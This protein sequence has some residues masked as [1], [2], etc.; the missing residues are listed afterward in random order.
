MRY[1][2]GF[3]TNVAAS[4]VYSCSS[5]HPAFQSSTQQE[6]QDLLQPLLYQAVARIIAQHP[7]LSTVFLDAHTPKP[8]YAQL[9]HVDLRD[10]IVFVEQ[11][12]QQ[13][14]QQQDDADVDLATR[15]P[16]WDRLLEEYHN[17]RFDDHW[18]ERPLWRL[19]I[20]HRPGH[21]AEFLACFVYLH[22]LCDGNSGPAFH[23]ALLAE[24]QALSSQHDSLADDNKVKVVVDPIVRSPD[25]PPLPNIEA[26]HRL[27]LSPPFLLKMAWQDAFPSKTTHVWLGGPV[28][29]AQPPTRSRFRSLTV[30]AATTA[31][32]VAVSRAHAS[33]LTA[34]V[35]ALVGTALFAHLPPDMTQLKTGLAINLRRFLPRDVVTADS[36]GNWVYV[37]YDTMHRRRRPTSPTSPRPSPPTVG[38]STTTTTSAAPNVELAWDD[39]QHVK[40]LLDDEIARAGKNTPMGCLRYAG[41]MHKFLDSRFKRPRDGSYLLSNLGVFQP[42]AN[43]NNNNNNNENNKENNENKDKDKDKEA[44][45]G[46]TWRTGRMIF[47]EGFDV[48]G[49]ALDITMITGCDGCLTVGFIWGEAVVEETFVLDVFH[50]LER[51]LVA[52]AQQQQQREEE[53]EEEESNNKKTQA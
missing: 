38:G 3:F 33:S 35:H 36:M 15:N 9:P 13:L 23:R 16:A 8:R 7:I 51:L 2:R 31:R 5:F 4:A 30:P 14:E 52:T 10:C 48:S 12:Q 22:G 11:Q 40:R 53:E 6:F 49:E 27:P 24:L 26:L 43:N 20:A 28:V 34:T 25:T 17:T 29:L 45:G 41:S 1:H 50:T 42:R 44:A 39:A 19:V 21:H 47:S 37:A 46:H 18:G 32:L